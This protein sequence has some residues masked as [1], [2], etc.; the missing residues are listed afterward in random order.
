VPFVL[1][2]VTGLVAVPCH[3]DPFSLDAPGLEGVYGEGPD[4]TYKETTFDFGRGFVEITD[5]WLHVEGIIES[6]AAPL[7]VQGWLDGVPSPVL[8]ESPDPGFSVDVPLTPPET[9]LDGEGILGLEIVVLLPGPTPATV[10]NVILWFEAIPLPAPT[11]LFDFADFQ[12]CFSGEGVPPTPA[13]DAFDYDRDGD[14]D[15]DDY[16]VFHRVLAGPQ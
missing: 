9:V 11:D 4:D 13:C 15:L 6:G 14:V 3:A 10:S 8:S 5:A 12:T 1:G 2:I 7:W 16:A